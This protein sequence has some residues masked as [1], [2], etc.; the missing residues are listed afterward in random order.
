M[1]LEKK[2]DTFCYA[3]TSLRLVLKIYFIFTRKKWA[4]YSACKKMKIGYCQPYPFEDGDSQKHIQSPAC[5]F[6]SRATQHLYNNL[7]YNMRTKCNMINIIATAAA[8][9]SL[10]L[11]HTD[12]YN[13]NPTQFLHESLTTTTTKKAQF[14]ARNYDCHFL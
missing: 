11:C 7:L 6:N 10:P 2:R 12:I 1:S 13:K 3:E 8:K 5:N 4:Q 9:K 14:C